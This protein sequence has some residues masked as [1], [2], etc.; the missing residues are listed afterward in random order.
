VTFSSNTYD[1]NHL[2]DDIYHIY[3]RPVP[4]SDQSMTQESP[5]YLM[6]SGLEY[7]YTWPLLTLSVYRFNGF[8]YVLCRTKPYGL[9]DHLKKSRR[10][11]KRALR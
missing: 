7:K 9:A 2:S 11:P 10:L 3:H 6:L 1:I 5:P 4:Y 8:A